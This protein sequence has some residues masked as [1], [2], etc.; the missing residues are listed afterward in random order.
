MLFQAVVD[1]PQHIDLIFV[2]LRGMY[3]QKDAA[4]KQK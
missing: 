4:Y 2:A 3:Y 1:Y